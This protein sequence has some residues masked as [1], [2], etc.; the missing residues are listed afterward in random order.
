MRKRIEITTVERER[1]VF[2]SKGVFCPVCQTTG[3]L[4]TTAQAAALAQV[5]AQSIRRWLAQNLAHGVK[6]CGGRHRVCKNSLFGNSAG[7]NL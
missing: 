6:T 2:V 3:E 7:D 5:K 4:L 1:I